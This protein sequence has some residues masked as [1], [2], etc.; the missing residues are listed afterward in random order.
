MVCLEGLT[1]DAVAK[2]LTPEELEQ[3]PLW[4]WVI[5]KLITYMH[6]FHNHYHLPFECECMAPCIPDHHDA[7]GAWFEDIYRGLLKHFDDASYKLV[8]AVCLNTPTEEVALIIFNAT[9]L[10]NQKGFLAFLKT[11]EEESVF[12]EV[13]E[14]VPYDM[15]ENETPDNAKPFVDHNFILPPPAPKGPPLFPEPLMPALSAIYSWDSTLFTPANKI[16]APKCYICKPEIPLLEPGLYSQIFKD[17][18]EL[19]SAAD[20]PMP[21]LN[22]LNHI[23]PTS[24]GEN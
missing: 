1:F 22:L 20:L 19:P 6:S 21:S 10:D 4:N 14:P 9:S 16:I 7:Y 23:A 17:D 15:P 3:F 13:L 8:R 11:V 24:V 18:I 12:E 2:T 5:H